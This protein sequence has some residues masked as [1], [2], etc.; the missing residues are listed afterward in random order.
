MALSKQKALEFLRHCSLGAVATTSKKTGPEV[1]LVDFA[2]SDE[3]EIVFQ[4]IQTTRKCL[5]LREDP[6]IAFMAWE[7]NQTLQ[8]EGVADEPEDFV[9]E[10]LLEIFFK[11]N[12]QALNQ[13][14]WPGLTYFRV[15]PTWIRL[16]QYGDNWSVE[17]LTF[18]R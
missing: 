6:R 2:V 15:R 8:Y 12:P 10:P 1:A 17:E 11:A 18:A 16:S 9:M 4:T 7:G 5:N 3:L 14:G 13:K